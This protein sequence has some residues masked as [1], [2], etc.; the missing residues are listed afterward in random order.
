[1]QTLQV[2]VASVAAAVFVALVSVRRVRAP[3][4]SQWFALALALSLFMPL[5]ADSGDGPERWLVLGSARLYVAP[6]VLPLIL[7]LLEALCRVPAIH[8]AS[9]AVAATALALQPDAAQLTAFSLAVPV[10]LAASSAQPLVRWATMAVLVCCAVVAWRTPDPLGPV[11]YVEGVFHLAAD[12]SPFA[13]LAALISAALPV[14]AFVWVARVT[15]SSGAVAVAVY[16]TSLFALSPLQVTP[17]PLLGFGAGPI[18]GYFLA[19]G[20]LTRASAHHADRQS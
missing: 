13:L 12:I 1:M 9:V 5:L 2:V 3:G 19:A 17:V 7:L 20:A 8:A 16:Y 10:L 11:R 18:L 6:I 14:M 4:D 15:R